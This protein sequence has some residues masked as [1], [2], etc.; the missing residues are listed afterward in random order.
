MVKDTR[1]GTEI[2]MSIYLCIAT[3]LPKEVVR[4]ASA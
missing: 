2:D 1:K 3:Y 4:L